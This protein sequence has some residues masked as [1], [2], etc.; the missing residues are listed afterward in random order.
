VIQQS[1]Y[2]LVTVKTTAPTWQANAKVNG[3]LLW[4]AAF[5]QEKRLEIAH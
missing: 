5:T 3:M 1:V 4:N 2:Y